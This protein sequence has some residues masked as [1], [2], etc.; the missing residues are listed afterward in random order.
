MPVL[1]G[2][3]FPTS[4]EYSARVRAWSEA[5]PGPM[6]AWRAAELDYIELAV[7]QRAFN[8]QVLE[9][10]V[11][12]LHANQ[13]GVRLHPYFNP[14]GFGTSLE[15]SALRSDIL[16]LLQIARDIA[17]HEGRP[18]VINFHAA[19]GTTATARQDL[20]TQSHDFYDWLLG[21]TPTYSSEIIIT[22]EFQLPP[23]PGENILR[24]GDSFEELQVIKAAL[25][26][27]HFGFCWD[28]GHAT[29]RQLFYQANP[30]PATPFLREVK[31]VH[32]HDVDFASRNDHRLIGT[33]SAPLKQCVQALVRAGYA[34][35]YTMEYHAEEMIAAD[36]GDKL[37]RSR[38]ALLVLAGRAGKTQ[39]LQAPSGLL[40]A[41]EE[42]QG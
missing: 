17:Q 25:A 33:G 20:R 29:M 40:K 6:A 1:I 7:K 26:H 4:A 24:I 37:R 8:W 35:G 32:I 5:E 41:Q 19:S 2:T 16:R 34:G 18:A 30:L 13:L 22:T 38:A 39:P 15:S 10:D 14:A 36:Y 12:T 28:M 42:E 27:K 9:R 11:E 23:K 31:H 21:V 3:N